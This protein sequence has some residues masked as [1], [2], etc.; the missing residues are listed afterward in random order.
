MKPRRVVVLLSTLACLL[1]L[2]MLAPLAHGFGIAKW[3][4]GTCKV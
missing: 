1:T 2:G 3:E 4:A